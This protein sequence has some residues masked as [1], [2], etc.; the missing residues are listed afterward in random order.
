MYCLIIVVGTRLS[1][2]SLLRSR[3]RPWI[4]AIFGSKKDSVAILDAISC[5]VSGGEEGRGRCNIGVISKSLHTMCVGTPSFIAQSLSI[6][7]SL[8]LR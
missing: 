5:L 6:C 4:F 3:Q 8:W 7:L 2:P 1:A